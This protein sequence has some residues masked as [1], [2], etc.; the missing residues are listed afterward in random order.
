MVID[1]CNFSLPGTMWSE[2]WSF[3]SA[4][5]ADDFGSSV[6]VQASTFWLGNQISWVFAG[7]QGRDHRFVG[8]IIRP[9]PPS[10]NRSRTP[11]AQIGNHGC[12]GEEV[13]GYAC[14]G[15][16]RSQ[17]HTVIGLFPDLNCSSLPQPDRFRSL[18]ADLNDRCCMLERAHRLYANQLRTASQ[19][20]ETSAVQ[21]QCCVEKDVPRDVR[22]NYFRITQ[23]LCDRSLLV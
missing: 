4:I 12:G 23:L 13:D 10:T 14:T 9:L 2:S 15:V 3:I 1:G 19:I 11:G 8:N 22:C 17:L 16:A 20:F 18:P 6:S 21:H 7:N 5:Y